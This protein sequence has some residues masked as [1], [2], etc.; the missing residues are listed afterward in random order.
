[1]KPLPEIY[2]K[3]NEL[4]VVVYNKDD[5][6]WAEEESRK[7]G[8]DCLLYLQPEWSRESKMKEE[9]INYIKENPKWRISLQSHKYLN[10]P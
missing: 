3:A 10:I 1:M 5:L 4:K 7:V 8:K 9:I 2:Q 6:K